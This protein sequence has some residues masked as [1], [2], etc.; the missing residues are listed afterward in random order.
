MEK[1]VVIAVTTDI[2]ND[3]VQFHPDVPA[4]IVDKVVAALLEIAASDEGKE[5]LKVAYQWNALEVHDDTFYDPFRQVLQA[6]G[7]SIE[8]LNK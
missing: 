3:G 4:D 1:V 6:S 8:E 2:P 5:A 7:L